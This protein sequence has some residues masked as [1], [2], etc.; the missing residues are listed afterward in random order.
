MKE[1]GRWVS[2]KYKRNTKLSIEIKKSIDF[3]FH[4]YT[5]VKLNI[6]Y[7]TIFDGIV[8]SD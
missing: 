5:W 8:P 3:L 1:S 4:L 6:I 7:K 2:Q